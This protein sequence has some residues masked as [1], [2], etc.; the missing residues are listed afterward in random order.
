M[1]ALNGGAPVARAAVCAMPAGGNAGGM[2]SIEP[3]KSGYPE[4]QPSEV[5]P[6]DDQ[7]RRER[8]EGS[9]DA[10]RSREDD[11]RATGDQD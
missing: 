3:S 11:G 5:V 2:E 1:S 4:E 8:G 6:E 7:R 10:D 9:D